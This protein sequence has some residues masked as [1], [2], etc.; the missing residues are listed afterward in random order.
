MTDTAAS[1]SP[2]PSRQDRAHARI[3]M[4]S[5]KTKLLYGFGSIAFGVKDHGFSTFLLFFYNQVI[6]MPA[7]VVGSAIAIALAADAFIDPI[8]GQISDNLHSRWGRRHPLMYASALP[9]AV[10]YWFL[11]N[12]PHLGADHLFFYLVAIT[13]LVRSL[14]SLYEVPSSAMLAE[15]THSYDKRT[16][17]FGFR[18][19]FLWV[20]SLSM[21]LLGFGLFFRP[22]AKYA[23]GQLDP[24]NYPAYAATA[25]VFMIVAIFVSSAG[26]HRFIPYLAQPPRRERP[27][28]RQI[29]REMRESASNRSFIVITLSTL[30]NFG[31]SGIAANIYIYF[32]TFFWELTSHEIFVLTTALIPTPLVALFLAPWLG[33]RLGKRRATLGLWMASITVNWAPFG[34]RM[35]G[36]FPVNHSPLLVPFL[37]TFY[38]FGSILAIANTIVISSMIADIVEDSQVKTGRRSEGLFFAANAFVQKAVS[39]LGGIIAGVLLSLAHFPA[40]AKPGQLAPG[41]MTHLAA[42]AV[43][44]IVGLYSMSMILLIFYNITRESH[45]RA[46]AT[47]ALES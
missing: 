34:L 7:L 20:G 5:L 46:V 42:F 12:P 30:F 35:I 11:W 21:S 37:L 38:L 23:Q 24:A 2:S 47:L 25:C 45:E 1:P 3:E 6:G 8:I 16:T 31:A 22:S 18:Y 9:L 29:L 4:N 15:L 19:L 41:V 36:L 33:K 43:P 13:I 17:M 32:M 10:S 44:A 28:L 26:T 39:G 27:G 14:I 40:M